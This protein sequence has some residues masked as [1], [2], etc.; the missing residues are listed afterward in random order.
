[1][2]IEEEVKPDERPV[3]AVTAPGCEYVLKYVE[4]EFGCRLTDEPSEATHG[5]GSALAIVCADG[6]EPADLADFRARAAAAGLGV[7]TLRVPYVIGTGMG[8]MM[9]RLARG[10]MRGTMLKIR[11]N[12]A[13]WSTVHA[14]DVARAA[15]R[16]VEAAPGSDCEYTV[17]APA[18]RVN[19][20]IDAL[21]HRIKNKRVGEIKGRWARLLYGASLYGQLTG[22][23]TVSTDEFSER[24]ADFVFADPAEYLKTHVYDNESL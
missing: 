3:L 17:S 8:G 11:G 10:V 19:D 7:A 12:E 15:S 18:V 6:G 20:L 14:T 4:R 23:R 22:D 1:M 5:C 21:G 13:R 2:F 16:I 24:F 9:M